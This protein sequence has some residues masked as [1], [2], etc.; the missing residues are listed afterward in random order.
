MGL[1]RMPASRAKSRQ[2]RSLAQTI[3]TIATL[4]SAL[5]LIQVGSGAKGEMDELSDLDLLLVVADGGFSK[6][7]PRRRQIS[8]DAV[9]SDDA[10]DSK[11]TGPGVHKWLTRDLVLIELLIGEPGQFRL[12]QP[13]RVV[14]GDE[15]CLERVP[16]RPPIDRARDMGNEPL[17]V[18]RAYDGLKS[19]VRRARLAPAAERPG[20]S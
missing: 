7:W 16:R 11:P 6:A 19:A 3:T 20:R 8:A 5:A 9:W 10:P 12:A 2:S 18:V 17:E 13:F 15:S 1:D 4:P 14:W